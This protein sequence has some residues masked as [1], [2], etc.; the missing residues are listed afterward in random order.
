MATGG[1]S[2]ARASVEF[3]QRSGNLIFT[4][5][6]QFANDPRSPDTTINAVL[7]ADGTAGYADAEG[8]FDPAS[9]LKTLAST[10]FELMRV[11]WALKLSTGSTRGYGRASGVLELFYD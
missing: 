7:I 2:G 5:A 9:A 6:V 11:G 3:V 8:V 10:G 1:V 4:A